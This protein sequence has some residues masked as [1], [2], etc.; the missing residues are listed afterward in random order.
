MQGSDGRMSQI[1]RTASAM[2]LVGRLLGYLWNK[3]KIHR[4]EVVQH[5]VSVINIVKQFG[6][7]L[8]GEWKFPKYFQKLT[9]NLY[10]LPNTI[11]CT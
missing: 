4:T 10:H 8:A 11:P 9:L 2:N 1:E 3:K 5:L 6:E 7:I